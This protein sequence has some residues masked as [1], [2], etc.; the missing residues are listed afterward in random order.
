MRSYN[1]C[2]GLNRLFKGKLPVN[3]VWFKKRLCFVTLL[4]E[5]HT[6]KYR[7]IYKGKIFILSTDFI[8]IKFSK[9]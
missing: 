4:L 2:M 9:T 6:Q 5:S 8:H 3:S 7:L 1:L